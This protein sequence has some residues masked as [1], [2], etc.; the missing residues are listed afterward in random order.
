MEIKP[1]Y[2]IETNYGTGPY[3][4]EQVIGP[5]NKCCEPTDWH[6]EGPKLPDHYHFD[7]RGKDDDKEYYLNYYGEDLKSVRP[8]VNNEIIIIEKEF[9]QLKL[10]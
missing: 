8:G 1:G 5:C 4:V 9:G 10:F 6:N 7:L 2:L 3:I